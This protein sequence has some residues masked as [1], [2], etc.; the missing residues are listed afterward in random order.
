MILSNLKIRFRWH[1]GISRQQRFYCF[2]AYRCLQ[3]MNLNWIELSKPIVAV[4]LGALA[5]IL[6]AV[7][8]IL[9]RGGI[10]EYA[11]GVNTAIVV[12]MILS[13]ISLF[14]G[15]M[16]FF[17]FSLQLT[18]KSTTCWNT[19]LQ[20]DVKFSRANISFYKSCCHISMQIG[21]FFPVKNRALPL[22]FF[23]DIVVKSTIELLLS[24][25]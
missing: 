20:N 11:Q 23:G 3:V 18:S 13:S 15:G 8:S 5:V 10:S 6:I 14:I 16:I 1:S 25:G 24:Y 2:R 17:Q 4:M 22:I 7:L 19:F 12:V 9:L 21:T